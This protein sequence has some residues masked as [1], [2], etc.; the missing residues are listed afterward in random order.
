MASSG[1]GLPRPDRQR[2]GYSALDM[3]NG[4]ANG[5]ARVVARGE[6]WRAPEKPSSE[7]HVAAPGIGGDWKNL[8]DV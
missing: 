3:T 7:V 6:G 1:F 2:L 5:Y 4:N 8:P